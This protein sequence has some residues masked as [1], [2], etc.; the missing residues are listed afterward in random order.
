MKRRWIQF[1]SAVG[2]NSYL[3][4]FLGRKI[5][6][7]PLKAVCVPFLNCYS[8]PGAWAS[9]PVGAFQ[10]LAAGFSR[11]ISLYVLGFL[12]T[13]GALAGRWVC[14]W[15]CPFGLLQEFLYKAKLKKWR[16]PPGAEY[17]KFLILILTVSLPFIWRSPAGIAEPYFCQYLCPAGTLEAGVPMVILRPELRGL[18]G[19]WFLLKAFILAGLVWAAMVIWRPFCRTL[20]PLGAFYG[21]F[22]HLS[23]WR[24]QVDE[25]R[26]LGC[27]ACSR[28]CPAD[29]EPYKDPNSSACVRCLECTR[30]CP[31][32]ALAFTRDQLLSTT[33]RQGKAEM[34]D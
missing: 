30:V 28:S 1:L 13:A 29:L 6:Q 26:C 31:T 14:G 7:G 17:G 2:A 27:G 19:P 23:W 21:L 10:S 8:C 3:P 32:A 20:C 22:N 18:V 4:G 25:A 33:C 12:T 24:L 11:T 15:L 16:L 5:Y 9:C 34:V